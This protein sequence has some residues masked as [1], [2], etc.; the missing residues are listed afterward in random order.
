MPDT[1]RTRRI[2]KRFFKITGTYEK[3]LFE[4]YVAQEQEEMRP[5][6]PVE[7]EP[8]TE[9]SAAHDGADDAED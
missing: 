7:E 5:D 3:R 6:M 8:H 1:R 2:S 9:E 4:D